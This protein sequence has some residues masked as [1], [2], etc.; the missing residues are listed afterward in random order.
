MKNILY[1]LLFISA[2]AWSHDYTFK[3]KYGRVVGYADIDS[4][5]LIIK[6]KYGRIKDVLLTDEPCDNLTIKDKYG[7]VRGYIDKD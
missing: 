3:D 6:N 7:K 1:L 4:G 2:S 5:R